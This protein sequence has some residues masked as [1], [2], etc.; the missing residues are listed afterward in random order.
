M[1]IADLFA[2]SIACLVLAGVLYLLDKRPK[3]G[4]DL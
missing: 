4:D 2:I 3:D 1:I